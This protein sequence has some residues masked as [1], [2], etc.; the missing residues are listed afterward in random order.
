MIVLLFTVDLWEKFQPFVLSAP[1]K[2]IFLVRNATGILVRTLRPILT[3][4][5]VSEPVKIQIATNLYFSGVLF[6]VIKELVGR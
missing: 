1:G 4:A 3:E 6:Y 2:S 5:S